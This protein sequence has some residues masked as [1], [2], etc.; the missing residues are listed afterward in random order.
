MI[1]KKA[2]KASSAEILTEILSELKAIHATLDNI[3]AAMPDK[4]EAQRVQNSID[5]MANRTAEDLREISNSLRGGALDG[6]E[7]LGVCDYLQK[8]A[9]RLPAALDE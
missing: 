2:R 1:G 5:S 4:D 7:Y 6:N 8:I 9:R 3:C